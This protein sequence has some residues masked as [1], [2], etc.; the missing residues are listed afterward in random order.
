MALGPAPRGLRADLRGALTVTVLALLT[1][2]GGIALTAV[3]L[4]AVRTLGR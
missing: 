4:V 1:F 3:V 2:G